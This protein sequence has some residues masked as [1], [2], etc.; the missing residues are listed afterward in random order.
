[1]L[2]DKAVNTKRSLWPSRFFTVTR[3]IASSSVLEPVDDA[4]G[5]RRGG[6]GHGPGRPAADGGDGIGPCRA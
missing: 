6:I 4:P 2:I 3:H 1:M 5:R